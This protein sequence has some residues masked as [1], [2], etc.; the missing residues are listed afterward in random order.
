MLMVQNSLIYVPEGI[1]RADVL[2]NFLIIGDETSR[3]LRM[4]SSQMS[5]VECSGT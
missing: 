4:C 2:S 3:K 1:I 5:R